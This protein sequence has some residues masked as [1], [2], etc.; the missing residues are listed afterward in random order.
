MTYCEHCGAADETTH[1]PGCPAAAPPTPGY[2]ETR[3]G[4][5]PAK[6]LN[7]GDTY[8]TTTAVED[9]GLH[10]SGD[11][12]EQYGGAVR[13]RAPGKGRFDLLSPF[14]LKELAVLAEQG[15]L[16]K[17][18]PRNWE[19]GYSLPLTLDSAMRHLQDLLEGKD[20][21][22]HAVMAMWNMM[23]F[24]H[25]RELIRRNLL[26][27]GLADYTILHVVNPVT[28]LVNYG[29]GP[30]EPH[31][32]YANT[33]ASKPMQGDDEHSLGYEGDG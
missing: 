3:T 14:A 25:V 29:D 16:G 10:D 24:I 9:F 32:V 6:T 1:L 26:P 31:D 17:Y 21:E 7:P 27:D 12:T 33:L 23:A 22:N 2:S 30:E 4:Q 13:D 28:G 18:A 11:R 20:D 15:A 5:G 8:T 19:R